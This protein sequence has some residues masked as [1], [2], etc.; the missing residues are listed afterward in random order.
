MKICSFPHASMSAWTASRAY[1]LPRCLSLEKTQS[2]SSPSGC[3]VHRAVAARF[4]FS[5]TPKTR[6]PGM[7]FFW[8]RYSSHNFSASRNSPCASSWTSIASVPAM[9][10]DETLI[11]VIFEHDHSRILKEDNHRFYDPFI[12]LTTFFRHISI[13]IFNSSFLF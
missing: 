3:R 4:P 11:V 7:S 12:I 5:K 1:P 2:I 10:I 8:P 9:R 13:S 6:S